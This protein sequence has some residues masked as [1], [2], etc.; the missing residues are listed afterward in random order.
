M[1]QTADEIRVAQ[2]G[3]VYVANVGTAVAATPAVPLAGSFIELGYVTEDG[4]TFNV[5]PNVEEIRSWQKATPTRRFVTGRDAVVSFTLQQ[6]NADNFVFAFGG[7]SVSEVSSGIYE[8]T[9][10]ADTDDLAEKCLVVDSQDGSIHDRYHVYRGS[11]M[12]GVEANLQRTG[13]SLL[14]ITFAALTPDDKAQ[15]WHYYTDD[16]AYDPS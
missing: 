3:R 15:P 12:E 1:A 5:T 9:P 8:Y 10:P 16:P 7:G 6:F 2:F 13:A 4:V 11:I 14:P